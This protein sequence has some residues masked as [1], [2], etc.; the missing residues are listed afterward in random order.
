MPKLE[1]VSGSTYQELAM[2]RRAESGFD[3]EE[4]AVGFAKYEG[5]LTL[6]CRIA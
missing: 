3:V 5:G 4:L 6:D 1:R 2:D